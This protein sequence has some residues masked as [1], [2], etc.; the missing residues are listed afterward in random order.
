MTDS[1]KLCAKFT[2][3]NATPS[4]AQFVVIRGKKIPNKR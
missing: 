4:T 1:V 2:F 3:N